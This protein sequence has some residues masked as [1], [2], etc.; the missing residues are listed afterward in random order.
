M[1]SPLPSRGPEPACSLD[2]TLHE[3]DGIIATERRRRSALGIFPA[4]YRSVTCDIQTAVRVG[5]FDDGRRVERLAVVFADRY[6]DAYRRWS[7]GQEP[8]ASWRIA[9]EAAES[10]RRRTIAQHLL[11][12]MN[13][14][15]NLDLGIVAAEIAGDDPDGL[16]ADFL[17]VNEI[18]FARLDMLQGRLGS[19][20]RRMAI[21]DRLGGRLD[22]RLMRLAIAHA[23]ERAW[24]FTLALVGSPTSV[25][26]LIEERD[27]STARLGGSILGGSVPIALFN[28]VVAATEPPDALAAIDALADRPVDLAAIN[29][30]LAPGRDHV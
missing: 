21:I 5:F 6:V 19:V 9:F 15:I 1:S 29:V 30:R 23:R 17:R 26:D 24:E 2:R 4:M 10:R 27:R 20:S 28:R 8:T 13:A 3:L 14:H 12:G 18:L 25:P 7:A 11:A 16:Y 22:E